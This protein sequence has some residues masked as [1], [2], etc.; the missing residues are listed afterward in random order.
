MV[1]YNKARTA[2]EIPIQNNNWPDL[3]ERFERIVV[4]CAVL[5]LDSFIALPALL[6]GR[7]LFAGLLVIGVLSHGTAIQRFFRARTLLRAAS[8]PRDER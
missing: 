6:G 2:M 3:M 5:I 8:R 4:L 7:V 1:S